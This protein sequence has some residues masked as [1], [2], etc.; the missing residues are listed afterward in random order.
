MEVINNCLSDFLD[1]SSSDRDTFIFL[2][3]ESLSRR[4]GVALEYSGVYLDVDPENTPEDFQGRSGITF[5]FMDDAV[6]IDTV[7]GVALIVNWCKENVKR[8]RGRLLGIC[9]DLESVYGVKK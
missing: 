2:L 7:E 3:L 4:E 1:L 8:D 9:S 5:S 6:S